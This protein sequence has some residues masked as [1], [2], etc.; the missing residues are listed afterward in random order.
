MADVEADGRIQDRA[1]WSQGAIVVV[2]R[3]PI[4]EIAVGRGATH[5]GRRGPVA[6]GLIHDLQHMI[7]GTD[8]N[9]QALECSGIT[10]HSP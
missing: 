4:E 10:D 9:E 5:Y 2:G 8:R 7:G 1:I 3:Q 6:G